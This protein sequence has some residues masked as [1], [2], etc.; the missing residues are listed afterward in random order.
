MSEFDTIDSFEAN[1]SGP[2]KLPNA[3]TVLTLGILSLILCGLIGIILASIALSKHKKDKEI[4]D[5]DPIAY[6]DSFK[7]SNAG[8]ICASIGIGLS[9]VSIILVLMMN[10][11]AL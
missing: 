4:Y 3:S 9:I 7:T 5:T 11:A 1:A 2:K 6:A 10:L 8:K